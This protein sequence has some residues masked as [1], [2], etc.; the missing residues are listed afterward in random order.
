MDAEKCAEFPEPTTCIISTVKPCQFHD[1]PVVST[2]VCTDSVQLQSSYRLA[3]VHDTC[4][5]SASDVEFMCAEELED[6]PK[7]TSCISFIVLWEPRLT[8]L[9][10]PDL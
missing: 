10:K 2:A 8:K 9:K 4:F 7:P 3:A 1:S 5:T 6:F